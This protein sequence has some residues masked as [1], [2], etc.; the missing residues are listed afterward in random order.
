MTIRP[1][2]LRQQSRSLARS[3]RRASALV[4]V[5]LT[6]GAGLAG[7]RAAQA[8][9]AAGPAA[10]APSPQDVQTATKAFQDGLKS[11]NAK[12]FGIALDAFQRSYDTVKSPNSLLYVARCHAELGKPKEAYRVYTRV[13]AEATERAATEAKYAPTRDTAK[14]ELEELSAKLA[15]LTI[16]VSNA[17]PETRLRVQGGIVAREEWGKPMPFDAGSVQITV[18]T[19]G[20]AAVERSIDLSIGVNEVV[21]LDAAPPAPVSEAPAE[22]RVE[23]TTNGGGSLLPFAIIAG[24]VGVVGMGVFA[25][26]GS[27]SNGT[28]SELEDACGGGPCPSS[29]NDVIDRGQTEQTIA[30]VGLIVGAVGLAAGA[31][32]LIVDLTSGSD[33]ADAAA[34][35][36]SPLALDVG[37][38]WI[39]VHGSF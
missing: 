2:A 4:A 27:M 5:A 12:K 33:G 36:P 22:T 17:S 6:L 18:D 25:V 3:L 29:Q 16:E 14:L 31:A 37:P 10:P 24:G 39:G 9:P 19:P 15:L 13:I 30:N 26:A 35:R 34:S 11:F 7:P 23:L 21:Q 20:R 8:Q 1:S 32:L 38:G 28:F